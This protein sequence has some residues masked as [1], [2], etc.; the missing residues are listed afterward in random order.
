[1]VVLGYGRDYKQR[2]HLSTRFTKPGRSAA[3]SCPIALT[4]YGGFPRGPSTVAQ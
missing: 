4:L 2:G 1:M 3:G